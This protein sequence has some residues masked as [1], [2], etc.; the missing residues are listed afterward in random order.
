MAALIVRAMT[1]SIPSFPLDATREEYAG[2]FECTTLS[3]GTFLGPWPG[4]NLQVL[5]RRLSD[6]D[7]LIKGLVTTRTGETKV[8][9]RHLRFGYPSTKEK[10][11][12]LWRDI[13]YGFWRGWLRGCRPWTVDWQHIPHGYYQR[14]TE[15]C[16][17]TLSWPGII[18][19][20]FHECVL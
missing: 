13:R 5:A 6:S 3:L 4:D 17:R 20:R 14:P 19:L 12:I 7:V 16:S 9:Y 11:R 18:G 8:Y 1:H 10:I 2:G 15:D